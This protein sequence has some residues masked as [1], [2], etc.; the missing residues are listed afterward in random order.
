MPL[1]RRFV[2]RTPL[3]SIY[4]AF[5]CSCALTGGYHGV[6]KLDRTAAAAGAQE[7]SDQG[8]ERAVT[9][10]HLDAGRRY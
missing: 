3:R 1:M 8:E 9:A 7:R 2:L 4:H 5:L 6:R 10:S